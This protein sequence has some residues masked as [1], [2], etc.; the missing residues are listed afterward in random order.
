MTRRAVL[1]CALNS[2]AI[3]ITRSAACYLVLVDPV[4]LDDAGGRLGLAAGWHEEV[5][6]IAAAP[7][8][9]SGAFLY[10]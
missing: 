5:E 6:A 7:L 3:F 1:P 2:R 10:F 9:R 8:S 4:D